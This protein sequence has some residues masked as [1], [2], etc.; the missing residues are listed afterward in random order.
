MALG[1]FFLAFVM[2][3][4]Q[5]TLKLCGL[6]LIQR[7]LRIWPAYIITMMFAGSIFL[8]M[9]SGPQWSRG[10]PVVQGCSSMW[11]DILFVG[12]FVGNGEHL[13]IGWGWYLQVDFQLFCLGV[14]LLYV[15]SKQRTAFFLTVI[16]MGIGSSIFVF[17]YTFFEQVTVIT[18]DKMR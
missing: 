14:L 16:F 3:R 11:K 8:S 10:E 17:L 1:G 9:G 7:A 6:G 4:Q 12:N 13:C 15:Y 5:I 18:S 2:I